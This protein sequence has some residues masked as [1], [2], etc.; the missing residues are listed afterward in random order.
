MR[1]RVSKHAV[2][3]GLRRTLSPI[4]MTAVTASV[5]LGLGP[6]TAHLLG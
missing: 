1:R 4:A 5:F 3:G 2:R 6:L